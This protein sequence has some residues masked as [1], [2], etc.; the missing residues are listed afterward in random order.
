MNMAAPRHRWPLG[1]G[2]ERFYGFLGGD[3]DQYN[4]DL[5]ADNHHINQPR[6]AEE[7]YH[8]TEDLAD[9]A[10][11]FLTDLR[12]VEPAKPF[13]LYFC[14]GAGHAP[15][16]VP[17]EWSERYRGVFDMGW[18]KA[19]GAIFQRQKDMGVVPPDTNLTPR[20]HW[21]QEWETLPEDEKRL[22]SR[23][24]EVYAGFISHTDHHIGRLIDYIEELGE[25]NNTIIVAI[26]DNGATA[27]GGPHGP[28]N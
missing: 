21:I 23:M 10:I 5:V 20:P 17:P 26:S 3:T 12:N 25:L 22:Y 13:F 24:M 16:H 14:T 27:E 19:R 6:T 9:K 7:G 15:H 4:P 8:L 18:D 28:L 2:F 1:R 11:E